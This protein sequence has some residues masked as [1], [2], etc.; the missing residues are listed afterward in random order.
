V[1]VGLDLIREF[2]RRGRQS[3]PEIDLAA[4]LFEAHVHRLALSETSLEL[5]GKDLYLVFAVLEGDPRALAA[6]DNDYLRPA[7]AGATRIDRDAGFL[8]NVARQLR[9]RLIA[10]PEPALRGY[11]GAAKL[12][13]W[14]QVA[15]LRTALELKRSQQQ[16]APAGELPIDRL[17]AG[18]GVQ[19]NAIKGLQLAD[20]QRALEESFRRLPTRQRT[21][22]RL[23]FVD[24][25]N[26]DAMATIYGV[27]RATVARWLVS[28]RRMLFAHAKELLGA[29]YPFE[30]RDLRTLYRLLEDELQVTLSSLL[31]S[32]LPA[33][34]RALPP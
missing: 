13:Q 9:H 6:F 2:H 11:A 4:N 1:A 20:F 22:L 29:T 34:N 25:L 5:H 18:A 15:A 3:Q 31:V 7:C 16:L 33:G 12:I 30:G 21:L 19:L 28:V 14:L 17:L 8:D 23:H 26:L 27:H 10:A 24:G 32:E